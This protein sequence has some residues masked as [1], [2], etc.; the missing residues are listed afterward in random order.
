M[1]D[2]KIQGMDLS[3]MKY[4]VSGGENMKDGLEEEINKFFEQ[5]NCY[6]KLKKGY[7]STEAVAGTTLSDDNCN[8]IGSI[9]IPLICNDFKIVKPET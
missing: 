6:Y 3:F 8:E 7:G 4:I 1:N 2:K 5:H 9:G